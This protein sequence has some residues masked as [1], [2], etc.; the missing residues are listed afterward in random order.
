MIYLSTFFAVV[1][2]VVDFPLFG[3]SGYANAL[4]L[5]TNSNKKWKWSLST[6]RI[7]PKSNLHFIVVGLNGNR[8]VYV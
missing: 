5:Q 4:S 1:V 2:S 8:E 7:K 3:V 6:V